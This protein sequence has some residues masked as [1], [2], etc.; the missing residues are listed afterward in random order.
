MAKV[1]YEAQ[2]AECL[3]M[4]RKA[5]NPEQKAL[6]LSMAQSWRS[7][8]QNAQKIRG[9]EDRAKPDAAADRTPDD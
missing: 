6:L 8:A 4:A 1:D 3:K 2:A 9:L 7:L 5:S